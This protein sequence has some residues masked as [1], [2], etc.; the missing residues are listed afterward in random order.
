MPGEMVVSLFVKHKV[1]NKEILDK[2]KVE[3]YGE[4]L[5]EYNVLSKSRKQI[6]LMILLRFLRQLILAGVIVFLNN[7]CWG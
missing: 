3:N 7:Y 2:E 4:M 6:I 5:N 1:L